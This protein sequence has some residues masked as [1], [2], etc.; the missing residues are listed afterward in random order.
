M[1]G[2]FKRGTEFSE[3]FKGGTEFSAADGKVMFLF[4]FSL[5]KWHF[6]GY[7]CCPKKFSL[8]SL[9]LLEDHFLH[10]ETFPSVSLIHAPGSPHS[11]LTSF[12]SFAIALTPFPSA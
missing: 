1:G 2:V 11:T 4:V 7:F 3:F 10:L 9:V 5:P 6:N 8:S 12:S